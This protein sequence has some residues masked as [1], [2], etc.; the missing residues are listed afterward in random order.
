VQGSLMA[1]VK[2]K[3]VK[4]GRNERGSAK[5]NIRYM[6]NR[7]GKDG[8]KITRTLFGN[9][10]VMGRGDAY[11]LIDEAEQGSRF[12]RVIV[13]PDTKT[14]D[15]KRDLNLREVLETTISA[16]RERLDIQVSYVVAI[17]ADHT[18]Q[19]HIHALVIARE[20]LLP[21]QLMIQTATQVCGE[22]RK[23][24][25]LLHEQHREQEQS[26]EGKVWERERSK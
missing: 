14:E 12:F 22:Q 23:Q 18:P 16:M 24:R 10:G 13:N 7:R 9:G 3:F 6:Q 25:D 1:I 4:P 20:R 2:V 5:A 15:T 11:N 21:A 17:H 8:A 26:R 19:R